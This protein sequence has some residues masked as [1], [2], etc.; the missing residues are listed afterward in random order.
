MGLFDIF[1]KKELNNFIA[2]KENEERERQ[3]EMERQ[4]EE[5]WQ[6]LK[7]GEIAPYMEVP[8]YEFPDG[9]PYSNREY[10]C[11]VPVR[12]DRESGE[13][14]EETHI[15][16]G[17]RRAIDGFRPDVAMLEDMLRPEN[18]GIPSLP[19]LVSD[20]K[21]VKQ[22]AK[23]AQIEDLPENC[24]RLMLRPFTPTG[25]N[26]RYPMSI[27]FNAYKRSMPGGNGSHGTVSYLRDG[28]VGKAEIHFWRNHVHYGA[29]YKLINGRIALNV[30]T[31]CD[32]LATGNKVELF[33]A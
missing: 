20:F 29:R 14:V 9:F 8:D 2:Q 12:F 18:V 17:D 33:R 16:Y 1:K 21:L 25:K 7:D 26:A 10:L 24:I 4:F 23:V 6:I 15:Y 32:N 30:L 5:E 11:H 19:E 13:V 3:E 22:P 27:G 28:S 31:Y